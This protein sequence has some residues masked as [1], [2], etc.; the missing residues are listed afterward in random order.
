LPK[1]PFN[2]LAAVMVFAVVVDKVTPVK[3]LVLVLVRV[4]VGKELV[5]IVM[6]VVVVLLWE[7]L[8]ETWLLQMVKVMH[9]VDGCT[10]TVH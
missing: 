5:V 7:V 4:V 3:M 2:I 6:V 9:V 10:V 1:P 8:V